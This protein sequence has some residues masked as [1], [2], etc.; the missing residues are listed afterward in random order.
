MYVPHKTFAVMGNLCMSKLV[1]DTFWGPGI[2][3]HPILDKYIVEI[4]S[5]PNLYPPSRQASYGCFS[6]T[7]NQ[8]R[9][10]RRLQWGNLMDSSCLYEN[11]GLGS[12]KCHAV[13]FLLRVVTHQCC[14]CLNSCHLSYVVWGRGEGG[15]S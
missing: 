11:Y 12:I 10:S 1:V 3:S 13:K 9:V 15:H 7:Q 2:S 4:R 14:F 6:A 8:K 5:A